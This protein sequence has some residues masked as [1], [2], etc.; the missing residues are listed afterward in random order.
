MSVN[1]VFLDLDVELLYKEIESDWLIGWEGRVILVAI[2]FELCNMTA[3]LW[4]SQIG[5][6]C[7]SEVY[8]SVYLDIY[9]GWVKGSSVYM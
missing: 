8:D 5:I 3:D 9:A 7:G 6:V 1:E 4:M 2:F